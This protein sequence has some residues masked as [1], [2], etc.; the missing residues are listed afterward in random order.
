MALPALVKESARYAARSRFRRCRHDSRREQRTD[1]ARDDCRANVRGAAA[2]HSGGADRDLPIRLVGC[3]PHR[4]QQCRCRS[5]LGFRL[6][7]RRLPP[8]V[9]ASCRTPGREPFSCDCR[10]GNCSSAE[11]TNGPGPSCWNALCDL[12]P[13]QNWW[14]PNRLIGCRLHSFRLVTNAG[15]E[16]ALRH[17]QP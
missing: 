1:L 9:R 7:H 5:P 2:P 4:R 12:A 17:S 3:P 6:N 10:L 15:H 13:C 14:A 11:L 8:R 16:R